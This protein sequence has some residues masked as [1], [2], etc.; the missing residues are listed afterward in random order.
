MSNLT[1]NDLSAQNEATALIVDHINDVEASIQLT[2]ALDTRLLTLL[3]ERIEANI[4]GEN[5]WW[6]DLPNDFSNMDFAPYAP[7]NWHD[8]NANDA[9]QAWFG[10]YIDGEYPNKMLSKFNEGESFSLVSRII[11]QSSEAGS[12]FALWFNLNSAYKKP[13]KDFEYF[14]AERAAKVTQTTGFQ[15]F[16]NG[17]FYLPFSFD[18]KTL[19]EAVRN[20]DFSDCLK[21]FDEALAK[22]KASVPVFTALIQEIE[23]HFTLSILPA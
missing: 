20:D 7:I 4:D 10:L 23:Q 15:F 21:P 12:G 13:K 18:A 11:Q 9:Y 3:K 5:D 2:H 19:S 6:I 1:Q 16:S 14:V 17:N 8:E 22:V